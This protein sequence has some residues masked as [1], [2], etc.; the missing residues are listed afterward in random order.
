LPLLHIGGHEGLHWT[1][2]AD[3][4]VMCFLLEWGYLF[5]VT[6]MRGR[7][8][9]AGRVKRS[10]IVLFSLG[11]VVLYIGGGPPVHDLAEH[12]LLTAHMLQH[13]AFTLI[14]APLLLAGTPGW[15]WQA[16]LRIPGTMPIARVLTKPLVAFA[17]FNAVL[18][19]VHLPSTID[20]QQR[21]HLF[22][23]FV[24]V[25]LVGSGLLMWWPILSSL[26]ELPRISYPLQMGYL[27]VQSLFPAVMASFVT[28]SDDV[29]YS[30][31]AQTPRIG[32]ISPI[33]DQQ[34]AG[35]SMKL[36]GSIIL[37]SFMAVAF[38]KW[39]SQE[40]AEERGPSWREVEEEVEEEL[41]Q[42]GLAQK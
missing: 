35:G 22:H 21:Q 14:A 2:H 41:E 18:L 40:E 27:F 20:L 31:Y 37:W 25:L 15:L 24:H 17:V 30:F 3:V 39:Y 4:L 6:Q 33:A 8:S 13:V 12:Y 34:I 26:T 9:D 19:L 42:I 5:A 32:G 7:V 36:V 29:V 28:F 1:P 16:L 11:V 23:L 38:F 10:Q